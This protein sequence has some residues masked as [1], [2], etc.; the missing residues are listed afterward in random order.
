MQC[1]HDGDSHGLRLIPA[2]CFVRFQV[3]S[4]YVDFLAELRSPLALRDFPFDAQTLEIKLT[5]SY[6]SAD[7]LRYAF[8]AR[9]RAG[10]VGGGG[11]VSHCV[12]SAVTND[13]ASEWRFMGYEVE[14]RCH[15]YPQ[16]DR[17]EGV[18]VHSASSSRKNCKL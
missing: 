6:W 1:A 5:S 8:S 13:A 9:A 15:E 7:D 4:R 14:E 16:F 18:R 17:Y 11:L 12:A 10:A 2:Y 3:V